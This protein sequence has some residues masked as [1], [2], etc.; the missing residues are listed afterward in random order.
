M[1]R[2][3]VLTLAALGVLSDGRV[4]AGVGRGSS[5]RDYDAVGVLFEERWKR[6]DEAVGILRSLLR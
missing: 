3:A 6:F 1:S 4:I 5:E 2:C